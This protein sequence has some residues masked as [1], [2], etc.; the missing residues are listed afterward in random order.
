MNE[1]ISNKTLAIALCPIY[2]FITL[3]VLFIIGLIKVDAKPFDSG[4]VRGFDINGEQLFSSKSGF[5]SYSGSNFKYAIFNYNLSNINSGDT[6]TFNVKPASTF[7]LDAIQNKNITLTFT[8]S[9]VNSSGAIIDITQSCSG[10]SV[11]TTDYDN[12]GFGFTSNA[13]CTFVAP[14][15]ITG[16][17]IRYVIG[18]NTTSVKSLVLNSGLSTGSY[19]TDPGEGTL[20]IQNAIENTNNIINNQNQNTDDIISEIQDMNGDVVTSVDALNNQLKDLNDYLN[21]NTKPN[22]DISSLGNVSGLLPAGPIDT[23]LNIPFNF[24]SVVVSS[25]GGVCVPLSG[26]FVFDSTLTLPCFSEQIYDDIPASLMVFIN[27]IP[28][29]FLLIKYF[30]HLYKKVERAT[31]LESTSDDEWGCI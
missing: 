31:S 17:A 28:T 5:Y 1:K 4:R 26:T 14:S 16:V 23:L 22:V 10:S 25:L 3:F 11:K 9:A 29:A 12:N 2:L 30:K 19:T 20:I 6:L 21:D 27:L 15:Q 13:V 8:V 7:R 18:A 24:L